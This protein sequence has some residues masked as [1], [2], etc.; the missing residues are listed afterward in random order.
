M[1]SSI[2]V[3]NIYSLLMRTFLFQPISISDVLETIKENGIQCSAE[4]LKNFF[5]EQVRKRLL[6]SITIIFQP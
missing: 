5:D 6:V 3:L 4:Q 1:A 2:Q